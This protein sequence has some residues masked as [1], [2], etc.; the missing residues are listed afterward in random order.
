MPVIGSNG[1]V[2]HAQIQLSEPG[3]MNIQVQLPDGRVIPINLDD[4][5]NYDDEDLDDGYRERGTQKGRVVDAD[6]RDVR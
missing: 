5:S 3:E 6:W 2:A 4:E 1:R